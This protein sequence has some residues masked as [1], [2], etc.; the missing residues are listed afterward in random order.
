M[1]KAPESNE[2]DNPLFAERINGKGSKQ[3][4]NYKVPQDVILERKHQKQL[5]EVHRE[6]PQTA[7]DYV[8]E[9]KKDS[10]LKA[11]KVQSQ[12]TEADN[13]RGF[14]LHRDSSN[15]NMQRSRDKLSKDRSNEDL[16]MSSQSKMHQ[17]HKRQWKAPQGAKENNKLGLQADEYAAGHPSNAFEGGFQNHTKFTGGGL[18]NDFNAQEDII[19]EAPQEESK[20]S[21]QNSLSPGRPA[22]ADA[23][24]FGKKSLF[25]G[26]KKNVFNPFAKMGGGPKSHQSNGSN[27]QANVDAVGSGVGGGGSFGGLGTGPA[28]NTSGFGL[29]NQSRPGGL[30]GMHQDSS[31]DRSKLSSGHDTSN[32]DSKIKPVS[33]NDTGPLNMSNQRKNAANNVGFGFNSGGGLGNAGMPKQ[34]KRSSGSGI[35][36]QI[37]DGDYSQDDF[38][39][40]GSLAKV[41]R[42]HAAEDFFANKND[43]LGGFNAKT[44]NAKASDKDSDPSGL[45][46]DDNYDN[47]FF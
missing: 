21:P 32:F 10:R 22:T 26:S 1:R 30:G 11:Q 35:D 28:A 38:E 8:V 34:E 16:S 12:K 5:D 44:N 33:L 24:A 36:E 45:G 37:S 9:T 2:I 3:P 23:N 14:N 19:K 41:G 17:T 31:N 27:T 4:S 25:G 46:F 18:A 13:K 7:S 40:G 29:S 15:E 39:L 6:R 47:D 43:G 20:R 42:Q